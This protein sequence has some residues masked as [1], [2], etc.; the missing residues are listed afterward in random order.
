M[1]RLPALIV[2]LAACDGGKSEAPQSRTDVAKVAQKKTDVAA[3]CDKQWK[4]EAAKAFTA[5]DFASGKLAPSSKWRWVNVWAT[6]CKPCVEEIPRI[7]TWQ[8]K[9]GFE[10]QLVSADEEE[11]DIEAF[12]KLHPETPPTLRLAKPDAQGAWLAQLG[13]DAG[14]PL[15]VHVFVDAS[16]HVRCVRAGGVREQDLPMIEALLAGR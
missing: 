11:A 13:L 9:L 14:A 1:D 6:W 16:N 5:P 10:L 3:F 4:A 15:P 2:L 8:K 12:R 7:V